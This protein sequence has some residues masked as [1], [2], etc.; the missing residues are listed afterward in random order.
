MS[1]QPLSAWDASPF[2][3]EVKARD[4]GMATSA[5]AHHTDL[6][7]ARQIAREVY[8]RGCIPIC[9]DDVRAEMLRR[10]PDTKWGNWAGSIFTGG[11]WEC[12]GWTRSKAK[13][14]HMNPIRL[15]AL[16]KAEV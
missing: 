15:W 12:K 13:G 6:R 9:A 2:E 14:A 10:F 16:R 4:R 8:L 3:P 5:A 11:A 7:I 1:T